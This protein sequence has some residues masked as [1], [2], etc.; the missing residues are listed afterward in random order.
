M[1]KLSRVDDVE[2]VEASSGWDR[3]DIACLLLQEY[4]KELEDILD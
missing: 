2:L 1:A 3:R 4:S